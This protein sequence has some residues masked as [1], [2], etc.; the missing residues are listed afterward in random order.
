MYSNG[1]DNIKI[2]NTIVF[3]LILFLFVSLVGVV[4]ASEDSAT[5]NITVTDTGESITNLQSS[6]NAEDN[7][8]AAN[9]GDI[10]TDIDVTGSTFQ[11][12]QNAIDA[13][14]EGETIY[15]GGNTFTASGFTINVNKNVTING[16]TR[17]NLVLF[18]L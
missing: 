14:S 1:G 12:I 11:D 9:E 13:A 5:N 6:G 15:L 4:C 2:K 7:L 10:L 18:Q 17:G 8:Q 16:G 3:I